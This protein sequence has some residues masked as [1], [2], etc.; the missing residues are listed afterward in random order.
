M[1]ETWVPMVGMTIIPNF[2]SFF[3]LATRYQ[4]QGYSHEFH[5]CQQKNGLPKP[6]LTS[7]DHAIGMFKPGENDSVSLEVQKDHISYIIEVIA[8]ILCG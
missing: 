2:H 7:I 8:F 5:R 1:K 6:P 3:L 4:L